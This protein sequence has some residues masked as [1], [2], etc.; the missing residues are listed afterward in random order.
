MT[1]TPAELRR[2]P[3]DGTT[4]FAPYASETPPLEE[5]DYVEE[6]WVATGTEDGRP[7]ATTVLVRRPRDAAR[8]SGTVV[9]APLHAHGIEPIWI[10]TAPYLLRS[11]HAWVEVTAQKTTLDQHVKP[12]NP[13]RYADL[14][15][16]GPDRADFDLTLHLDDPEANTT[17]WS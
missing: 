8:F 9:V 5:H 12:S 13:E 17:F 15:I 10:Y 4:V 11:G 2:L 14:G 3:D 16:D 7:Y 1:V 6:E